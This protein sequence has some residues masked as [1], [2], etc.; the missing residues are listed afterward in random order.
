MRLEIV[1]TVFLLKQVEKASAAKQV[2]RGNPSPCESLLDAI[3]EADFPSERIRY[4]L[5]HKDFHRKNGNKKVIGIVKCRHNKLTKKSKADREAKKRYEND[6]KTNRH[7]N[8]GKYVCHTKDQVWEKL[9][10]M[11]ACPGAEDRTWSDFYPKRCD[12]PNGQVAIG[13]E[14]KV[15]GTEQCTSCNEGHILDGGNHCIENPC[16]AGEIFLEGT[17]TS[18][19]C[20]EVNTCALLNKEC[21]HEGHT[22]KCGD[23]L[24]GFQVDEDNRCVSMCE[25]GYQYSIDSQECA[26]VNECESGQSVT[27]CYWQSRECINT[28]GSYHCGDCLEGLVE[29]GVA[30]VC[31]HNPCS[32]GEILINGLCDTDECSEL[33]N[34]CISNNKACI[35]NVGSYD[36]GSC[37]EGY[38][39]QASDCV[40]D[41]TV[42]YNFNSATN[43]CEDSDECSGQITRCRWENR[44][45]VN[46]IGSYECGNCQGDLIEDGSGNC[47][48]RRA[49]YCLTD[50]RCRTE[51]KECLNSSDN[52]LGF[53]CGDC[54]DQFIPQADQCVSS[55][56]EGYF[57]DIDAG[58]CQ[59]IDEC[60]NSSS[61]NECYWK[62]REC[63]N[64][65]GSY[66]CGDCNDGLL[67]DETTK[68]CVSEEYSGVLG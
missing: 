31:I 59:D 9:Y 68:L 13:P 55:C 67:E 51:N 48:T 8:M 53:S 39:Q 2:V 19:H 4:K 50:T 5:L 15:H 40:E 1:A 7:K 46:T 23:C 60:S 3:P 16:A 61:I 20:N 34:R 17:C 52:H 14:C 44:E 30:D 28:V 47:I 29:T 6:R 32:E 64:T 12:C 25:Q 11:P 33:D 24:P 26:D 22:Y 54:L 27:E 36:C 63:I 65:S 10:N 49:D 45:C 37:L 38:K 35:N 62:N 42:G 58:V 21:L 18:N 66:T 41:C 57:Y 56:S 43:E